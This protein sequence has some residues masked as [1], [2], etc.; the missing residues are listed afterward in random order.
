MNFVKLHRKPL[1][2]GE[3]FP[4]LLNLDDVSGIFPETGGGSVIALRKKQD[5]G[6]YTDPGFFSVA[7]TPEEMRKIIT[8]LQGP[9]PSKDNVA[10][11]TVSQF[12]AHLYPNPEDQADG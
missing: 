6:N 10:P 12:I 4:I 3:A 2:Y 7:E 9:V 1:V 11:L 8:A 5:P